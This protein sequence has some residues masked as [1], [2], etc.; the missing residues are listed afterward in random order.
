MHAP[1]ALVIAHIEYI[2]NLIS[3]NHV[4]LGSDFDGIESTPE[5][6]DHVSTYLRI[7]KTFLEKGYSVI[8]INKIL[9]GNI[10]R[11]L[12]LMRQFRKPV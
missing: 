2:I 11:V 5:R 12:K 1:F 4:D 10:L 7:T 8:D 6:L 3:V 9:G